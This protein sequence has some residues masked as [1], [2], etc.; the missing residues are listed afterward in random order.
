[1][2]N[3]MK[4]ALKK[5]KKILCLD[6]VVKSGLIHF[7]SGIGGKSDIHIK[8]ELKN[9]TSQMIKLKTYCN[10]LSDEHHKQSYSRRLLIIPGSFC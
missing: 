2:M 5:M 1:M 3:S 4:P 9:L 7:F 10:K 8:S 6:E